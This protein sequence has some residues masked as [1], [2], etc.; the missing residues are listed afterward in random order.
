VRRSRLVL[1]VPGDSLE[2][3]ESES[4]S[5]PKSNSAVSV[6]SSLIVSVR[7]SFGRV[8]ALEH[9]QVAHGITKALQDSE[10]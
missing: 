9:S 8:H 1:E 3:L 2:V 4:E 6:P 7:V 5:D 10:G